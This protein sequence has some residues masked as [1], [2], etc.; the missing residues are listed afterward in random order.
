MEYRYDHFGVP[1]EQKR[2]GMI[3]FPEY[4]VWC[5]DYEKDPYRIEWLFFEEG[6][7]MHPLI[8][9]VSHVCFIVEDIQKAVFGKKLLLK[10]THYEGYQMAFVEEKGVPIEFIQPLKSVGLT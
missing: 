1:V 4:K 7:P 9:T 3:Y 6:S 8:Q 2:A 10:P 5:A